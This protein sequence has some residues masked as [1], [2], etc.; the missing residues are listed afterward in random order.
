MGVGAKF[1]GD[2]PVDAKLPA[3]VLNPDAPLRMA[4]SLS[5]AHAALGSERLR[6]AFARK[7]IGLPKKI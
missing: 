6:D 5:R 3:F 4:R 7:A 1:I 2:D